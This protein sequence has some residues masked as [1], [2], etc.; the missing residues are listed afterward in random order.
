M[1]LELP[2]GS[3]AGYIFDCDGTI[4]D[5]MPLHYLAWGRALGEA[6]NH[7]TREM[8]YGWGGMP[9]HAIVARLNEE[10]GLNLDPSEVM[11]AK[12][13]AYLEMV[14][15]VKPVEPVLEI[16]RSLHGSAPLA[17]ASGGRWE[18]VCSTLRAL[19]I[20]EMF[21]AVVTAEHYQ[22]GK[23]DP[24]PFLLAAR[25]LGVPPELCLVFEDSPTGLEAAH[26]AGMQAVFVPSAP[27]VAHLPKS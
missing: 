5:T 21:D 16:A 19:D 10:C 11:A 27:P 20:L 2:E 18:L 6:A 1:Q 14:H 12:E 13:R 25:K 15:E 26:R 4:A 3:F 23:P 22:K 17:I 9:N 7:F 24:E 8:H